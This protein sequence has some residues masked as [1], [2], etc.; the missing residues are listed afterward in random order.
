MFIK[1]GCHLSSRNHSIE[2]TNTSSSYLHQA[3]S[4]PLSQ[5]IMDA[6]TSM[7]LYAHERALAC[8]TKGM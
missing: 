1:V 2:I 8:M 5:G 4:L 3:C 6:G 7:S